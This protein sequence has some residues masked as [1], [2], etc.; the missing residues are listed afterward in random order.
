MKA[1]FKNYSYDMLKM[2]LNQFGTAIFGFSLALA[3]GHAQSA[4]LRNVTSVGAILFYLFLLYTMTWD[5]GYRDRVSVQSGR[6]PRRPFTGLLVSLCANSVNFLFALFIML[7]SLCD[8]AFTASLGGIGAFCA[9]VLEG[10]YVGL[11]VNPVAGA[12]LN[13]YW[14]VYFLLPIPA[15][16]LCT[17]TYNLGLNDVKFT[18]AFSSYVNETERERLQNKRNKRR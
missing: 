3:A 10:M 6:V 8:S 9:T 13:S 4:T 1:F 5:M 7:G 15:L 2:F 16:L 18:S 17:V 11:L 14:W 12:A